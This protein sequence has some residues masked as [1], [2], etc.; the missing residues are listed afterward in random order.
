M[1]LTF[2]IILWL[3]QTTFISAVLDKL[4]HEYATMTY[5]V[6]YAMGVTLC[7]EQV[8]GLLYINAFEGSSG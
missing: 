2:V 8:V 7:R 5:I 3:T 6:L 1:T 4:A